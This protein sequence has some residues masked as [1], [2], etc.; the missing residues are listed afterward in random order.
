MRLG[1]SKIV[2]ASAVLLDLTAD[3]IKE[4]VIIDGYVG[5]DAAGNK[6]TGKLKIISVDDVLNSTSENPVQ[7]KVLYAEIEDLKNRL[8]NSISGIT[9]TN[10]QLTWTKNNGT[11]G[12]FDLG[13]VKWGQ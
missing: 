8:N 3:T 9:V 6:V 1:V 4:D 13:T 12:S 7:N 5:H 10:N 2:Y 11:T